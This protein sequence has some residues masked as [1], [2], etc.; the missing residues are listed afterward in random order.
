MDNNSVHVEGPSTSNGTSDVPPPPQQQQQQPADSP[1]I[2]LQL[3]MYGLPVILVAGTLGNTASALVLSRPRMR[4]KSVYFYLLLLAA[5]D[6]LV[7]IT[8]TPLIEEFFLQQRR[9]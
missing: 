5:A 9:S 4:D 3:L 8:M 2:E 6:T 7:G 1:R